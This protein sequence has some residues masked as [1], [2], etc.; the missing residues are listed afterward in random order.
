MQECVFISFLLLFFLLGFMTKE[1]S[2]FHCFKTSHFLSSNIPS[3]P[4]YRVM[5]LILSAKLDLIHI[6][7]FVDRGKLLAT[8]LLQKEACV[9]I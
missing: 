7:D 4:A 2:I 8:V 1:T 3:A 5:G 6:F 9:N